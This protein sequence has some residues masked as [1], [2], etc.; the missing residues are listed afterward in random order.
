MADPKPTYTYLVSHLRDAHP[1][2]AYIHLVEPRDLEA[3]H[4]GA[5]ASELTPG[6]S[7]DFIREIWA[8]RPLVSAG[9]YRRELALDFAEKKG[10]IIAFGR[11]FIA[12]VRCC[13]L[14]GRDVYLLTF[15]HSR[16]SR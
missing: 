3:P 9:G 1:D 10:D 13:L 14:V 7:N 5:D 12:N 15:A 11:W 2:L 8:P 16:T 4:P 6:E